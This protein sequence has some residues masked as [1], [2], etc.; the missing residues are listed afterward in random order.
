MVR[1]VS[2]GSIALGLSVEHAILFRWAPTHV[3]LQQAMGRA[4]PPLSFGPTQQRALAER[5]TGAGLARRLSLHLSPWQPLRRVSSET[6]SFRAAPVVA[7]PR[8]EVKGEPAA[9]RGASLSAAMLL[10]SGLGAQ[11]RRLRGCG[12]HVDA[13]L[14]TSGD[15]RPGAARLRLTGPR[16]VVQKPDELVGVC[17]R[18]SPTVQR[19]A[20][21]AEVRSKNLP[22]RCSYVLITDSAG[23]R[24]LVQKRVAWKETYPS[25]YDPCPGGVMGPNETFE[26]NAVRELEEEM[27][28]AIGSALAPE[29]PSFLFDFW[30]ENDRVRNW[31][32]LLV[33]RFMGELSDLKLQEEEVESVAWMDFVELE[34]LLESGPITPDSAVAL[35][36]WLRDQGRP[37]GT[38]T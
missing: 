3:P 18:E 34:G 11:H 8:K 30:F 7:V 19:V 35:R 36:R 23:E 20:S 12:S 1:G 32:R 27:G 2:L 29:H 24:V 38:T 9:F 31:G 37:R 13:A 17:S 26:E 10:A 4:S 25:H 21:R 33:V 5:R 14:N 16:M 6:K 28:I 22:H 15:A